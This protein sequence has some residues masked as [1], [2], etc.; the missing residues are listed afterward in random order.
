MTG[1]L[2]LREFLRYLAVEKGAAALT[3]EA[4][5]RDLRRYLS[6][7]G[8]SGCNELAQADRELISRF[9]GELHELGLAP[10]S[11]ERSVSA[12]KV[13]HR[14]LV[15]EG[16]LNEDATATL[17]LPKVPNTLPQTLSIEQANNLLDQPFPNT[18]AGKRDRAMLELLY[19]C[20]LRV[21]E[22]T[23]LDLAA[24]FL[25]DG[26]LRIV[27]KGDKERLAPISGSALRELCSYLANA[28]SQLHPKRSLLPVDGSAVFLNTRGQRISRQGVFKIVEKYGDLAGIH[29]LHPHTLR[30]SF[31]TH[32]LEGGADLR[33]IQELLGH[34]VITTTQVYTHVDRSHI[35]A[36]Y[37]STHPRATM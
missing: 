15:R 1:E 36:E 7:L 5:R 25:D 12:I 23:G 4:Y 28:R 31:A 34:S 2:A 22:L 33:S 29:G 16:L 8:D 32:L 14:F 10:A 26:Y 35:R 24:L 6:W 37:L 19:G 11:V 27:G 21:S 13:F 9:I 3:I 18:A 20:G 17:R 30:H